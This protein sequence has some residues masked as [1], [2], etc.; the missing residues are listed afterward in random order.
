MTPPTWL[1]TRDGSLKRGLS[2]HTLFVV[3][4]GK[5]QYRL[6]VRPAGGQ[7][8]CDITQTVN[9][10]RLDDEHKQ[11]SEDAAFAAGLETLRAKLGW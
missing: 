5:P 10:H 4:G 1:T 9:G 2:P 11:P 6:D 3:Y 8:T 7:F